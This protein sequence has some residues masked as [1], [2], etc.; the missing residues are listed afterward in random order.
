MNL[1]INKL[2]N[3]SAFNNLYYYIVLF[4]IKGGGADTFFVASWSNAFGTDQL[5]VLD[6]SMPYSHLLHGLSQSHYKCWTVIVN[7]S[8]V[9][10]D[11]LPPHNLD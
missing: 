8:R 2:N 7:Y 6:M 11:A 10:L 3:C 4:E 1:P 5:N 9:L